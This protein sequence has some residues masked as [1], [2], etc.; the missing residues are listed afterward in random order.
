MKIDG[1]HCSH[2]EE[3]IKNALMSIKNVDD[4]VFNGFIATITYKNKVSKRQIIE[5]ILEKG[6]FTRVY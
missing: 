2:C 6:Y 3:T 5:K 4:V 1:M